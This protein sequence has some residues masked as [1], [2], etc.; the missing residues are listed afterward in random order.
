MFGVC[1][2]YI[3]VH[4]HQ[5]HFVLLKALN[6]HF[7]SHMKVLESYYYIQHNHSRLQVSACLSSIIEIERVQRIRKA[8]LIQF[9]L[10]FFANCNDRNPVKRGCCVGHLYSMIGNF[11]GLCIICVEPYENDNMYQINIL[12]VLL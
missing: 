11:L 6:N 1:L 2:N 4:R 7:G 3:L 10:H 5:C 9:C 12:C 8:L